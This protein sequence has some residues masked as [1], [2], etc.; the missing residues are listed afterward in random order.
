MKNAMSIDLEDWF[1][2]HNLSSAIPGED[3][4][5]CELR[6]VGNTRRILALLARC[7][8]RAT[9]FVLGWIAERVPDLIREIERA[10]HEIATHGYS[11][12][13]LTEMTPEA[14]EEDLKKALEVTQGLAAQK[15]LGF[16]APS[17]TIVGKTLWAVD[18][19]ARHGI[20]YDSSLFP[21]S[22]HPDYGVPGA[23]LFVHELQGSLTE[24]PLTCAEVWGMRIPCSG[25]G[26]FRL[27][28]YHLTARLLKRCNR[29]GRPAVFYLHPWELDSEMPRVGLP[30]LKGFRHYHN[31]GK[32]ESRL[33]RLLHDFEFTTLRELLGL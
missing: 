6:V 8:T 21:V 28:P 32:T 27:F 19:L 22:L 3:W 12:T 16:R 26:Y 20:R 29:Q 1:C 10:G 5:R 17:F 4:G 7:D 33:E 9:F 11:H 13:L 2:A 31:L 15:I 14:F 25:G 30:W 18:I 23:P 24:V